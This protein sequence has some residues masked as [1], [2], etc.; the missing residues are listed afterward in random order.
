MEIITEARKPHPNG[1]D[2]F[3]FTLQNSMGTKVKITNYGA[4]IMAIKLRKSDGTY[5]DIVLGFDEPS[6]YWSA[7]Y[8][9]NYPYYG[10]A[11]G[12]VGNRIAPD[13]FT[14]DGEKYVLNT[15]RDGYQLHGGVEGFDKKVWDVVSKDDDKLVL[16]YVSPDGEEGYPGKLTVKIVFSLSDDNELSYEYFA[17]TDKPTIVNM[18][19]HSYFNLN[20]G[21]RDIHDTFIRLASSQYLEQDE[22][23]CVT[24]KVLPV[25]GTR[26][27][28]SQFRTTGSIPNPENGIDISFPLDKQGI[29]KM[30]AEAY[31]GNTKLEIFTTAPLV[32]LYNASGSPSITGKGGRQYKPFY[33]FCIETQIHPNAINIPSFPNVVLRP[34]ET[35]HTKTVYKFTQK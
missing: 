3:V 32:H 1:K 26:N 8:L 11:V 10:A 34:G 15:D 13:Y 22:N 31:S 4:I 2:I 28:F 23:F 33:G 35:Y 9:K 7:E 25:A 29:E 5:N 19:H 6:D 14:I 24:G 16:Q 21:Q 30:A 18:T 27:D 17:E 12:R 20:D